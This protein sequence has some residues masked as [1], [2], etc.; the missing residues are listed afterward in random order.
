MAQVFISYVRKDRAV[1]ARLA[2]E[3]E[4]RGY[5]V[6]WDI[7]LLSGDD[8]RP[9]IEKELRAASAV[10]V[11][12]SSGSVKSTFV[13]SEAG[14]GLR[15]RILLPIALETDLEL[16]LE[17]DQL[18]TAS[19]AEWV[20]DPEET[21]AIDSLCRALGKKGVEPISRSSDGV[22]PN[23][24]EAAK[25]VKTRNSGGQEDKGERV[26]DRKGWSKSARLVLALALLAAGVFGGYRLYDKIQADREAAE[27][28]LAASRRALGE[29]R[30]P[31]TADPE[32]RD[33]AAQ[34]AM[35]ERQRALD[36]EK[37]R[38]AAAAAAAE[39][40]RLEAEQAAAAA[41]SQRALEDQKRRA[42]EAAEKRW[43]DAEQ[44]ELVQARRE[45]RDCDE[46][47]LMV[48]VPSGSFNMG[49]E[50]GDP[51]ETP[52]HRVTIARP[53]AVGRFEVT[54]AQWDACVAAQGC[55]RKP[56]DRGWG[57]GTRPVIH[58]SWHDAKEYVAWL[59]A[60]TGKGYR[61]LSES[62]WEY[63]A[64]GGSPTEVEG[65][66]NANCA[67]C[68]SQYD[69]QQTAPVGSF[70][71]NGFALYDMIGNVW[72]WTEDCWSDNYRG[73][74]EDGSARPSG[75]CSLRVLRGGSWDNGPKSARSA[76]RSKDKATSRNGDSG[77]RVARNL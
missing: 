43:R 63:A 51:E 21:C 68:G 77:F 14:Y 72:E 57:R 19:F 2:A 45:F 26:R 69:D 1:V 12:W 55:K 40:R 64:R 76:K 42:A 59:S 34:S 7:A 58:V 13:R 15:E 41:A 56:A 17:F 24:S 29:E 9:E 46:C 18:Q 5:S 4:R 16:P 31:I 49:S 27:R 47:P 25:D 20:A 75:D 65:R 10:V 8:Y 30:R 52:V 32:Q 53:F 23:V 33:R 50:T 73:A 71:P 60:R 3:L 74:P 48:V 54:F 36:D 70:T 37:R 11:A 38:A 35:V 66:R 61:L 39:R 62:E 6:W 22:P 67:G 28:E 44:A